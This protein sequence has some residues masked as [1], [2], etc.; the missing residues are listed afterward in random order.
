[1]VIEDVTLALV[2]LPDLTDRVG[3][4]PTVYLAASAATPTWKRLPVEVSG[5]QLS[6]RCR[7]A[8]RKTVMGSAAAVLGDW[9][10]E[11]IDTV[12][13]VDV[14][15]V[16]PMQW[17]MSC[18]D[19][20]LAAGANLA[21]IGDELVQFADAEAIGAGKFRLTRLLRG[22]F[23]TEAAASEHVI[24]DLFV[25]IDPA[26]LQAISLP[27]SARDT[28][29]TAAYRTPLGAVSASRVIDGRSLRTGLFVEGEK[30]VGSR[31]T[32]IASPSGG[33]TIDAEV[34]TAVSQI[35]GTLRTHGLIGA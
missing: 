5:E 22:R 3:S 8:S 26:A 4:T 29:V 31:G 27:A 9:A 15:L 25:L 35:L 14:D 13:S 16:D 21:L 18:D 1:M 33:E 34:R 30:V 24:G 32:A 23:A 6:F 20:A 17:L 10:V 2:E 28:V 12:S 11:D 19:S 7:T